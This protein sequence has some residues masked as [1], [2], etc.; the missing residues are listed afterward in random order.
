MRVITMT[1]SIEDA[2]EGA[3]CYE[4]GEPATLLLVA[5]SQEAN[6]GYRDEVP[7]CELCAE[8]H[9]I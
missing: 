8:R 1:Y 4:C 6:T 2:P 9:Q 3:E 5:D 7:L